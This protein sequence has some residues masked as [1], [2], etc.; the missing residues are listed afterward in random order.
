M[1]F[2]ST[3]VQFWAS[4]ILGSGAAIK[5]FNSTMVQ[6]WALGIVFPKHK[7]SFQ[8]HYGAILGLCDRQQPVKL[9]LFQFHYGAILGSMYFTRY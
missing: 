9:R 5:N 6:F 3:M 8:F 4:G 1:D 2:N 7:S